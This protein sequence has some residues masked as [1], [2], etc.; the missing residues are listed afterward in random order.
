[1][2]TH[3]HCKMYCVLSHQWR[4]STAAGQPQRDHPQLEPSS[5]RMAMRLASQECRLGRD[6]LLDLWEPAVSMVWSAKSD[7][8]PGAPGRSSRSMP[9]DRLPLLSMRAMLAG[10][11]N[12]L[13]AVDGLGG[14]RTADVRRVA[15][16]GFH[17][18]GNARCNGTD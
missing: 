11:E 13:K 6:V 7:R 17:A 1:M 3:S 14:E 8:D 10:H 2:T 5:R 16:P 12:L 4:S 15:L 18:R 9:Y